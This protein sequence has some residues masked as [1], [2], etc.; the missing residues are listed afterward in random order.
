M[1]RSPSTLTSRYGKSTLECNGARIRAHCRH[2]ATVVTIHGDIGPANADRV[3][4]Y[5]RRFVFANNPLVIDLSGVTSFAA[6]A[7]S[8]CH[9][10]DE[11]CRAAGLEWTLVA[12]RPV[13]ERLRD[14][15]DK[16]VFP[17]ARSAHEALRQFADAIARRR[18][19]MLP[20]IRKSA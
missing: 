6:E 2:L 9:A 16:A 4:N 14:H 3:S 10:V 5:V 8:L 18:E 13:A 7:V 17:M 12:S 1:N 15:D 11:A 19:V 20:L